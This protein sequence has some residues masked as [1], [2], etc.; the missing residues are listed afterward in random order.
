MK[1]YETLY[2]VHPALESGRLKD[3]IL[4][5]EESLTKLGGETLSINV[6]GKKR[7]AYL[8]DKQKYGTYVQLQFTGEG[9][10][11]SGFGMELEHNPNILSYLT[12]LIEKSDIVEPENDLDTQI[13]GQSR[14]T[15]KDD[16]NL[17]KSIKKNIPE[18]VKSAE[19]DDAASVETDITDNPQIEPSNEPQEI[20]GEVDP[21]DKDDEGDLS[22]N[23]E[24]EKI[25]VLEQKTNSV[26]EE[27][28]ENADT[29]PTASK[30]E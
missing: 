30:E 8:I 22:N 19:N 29:I 23:L 24:L 25:D 21:N 7:L 14:E 6:W 4:S 20:D 12:T 28:Q 15:K 11:I 5:L 18:E 27:N 10:C 26:E 3:I 2:I 9:S 1:Y 16:A 17:E 13:A